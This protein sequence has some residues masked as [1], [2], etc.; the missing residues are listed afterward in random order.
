MATAARSRSAEAAQSPHDA[1]AAAPETAEQL[2]ELFSL[3]ADPGRLRMLIALRGTDE[4]CVHDLAAAAALSD[5]AASHA[6]RLLR[7]HRV[8]A[9]R[10]SGRQALY[11]LD[12][13]RI[14][15]LIDLT[16]PR[17]RHPT[18]G[19]PE[20]EGPVDGTRP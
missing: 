14:R 19:P 7:A 4:L 3:L 9:V 18:A 17:P 5:S 2:A 11:R 13:E 6:L 16:A 10:R 1:A 12:D 15:T 8:V 20:A